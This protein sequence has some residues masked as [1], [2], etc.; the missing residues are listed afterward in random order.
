MGRVISIMRVLNGRPKS[1]IAEMTDETN[2]S[3]VKLYLPA[4]SDTSDPNAYLRHIPLCQS[5][6]PLARP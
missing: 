2:I 5:P 1:V 6:G 4:N 3:Q